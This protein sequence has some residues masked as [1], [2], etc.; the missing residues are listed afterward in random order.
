MNNWKTKAL[1]LMVLLWAGVLFGVSFLATPAKFA[2]PTLS[3]GVAVD[4]GRYTF[5]IL[6]H[7]E[8]LFA[9]GTAALLLAGA[10]RRRAAIGACSFAVLAV[11]LET[12]WLLPVLDRRAQVVIEGGTL[13]AS[14]LHEVY[15][16]LDA[17]R[18]LALLLAAVLLLFSARSRQSASA[19]ETLS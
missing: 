16:A 1:I 8:V 3:L 14:H 4:V 7:T 13:T 6:N 18:F 11:L 5:R 12:F 9:G 15:I 10:T 19:R 2:A 17:A